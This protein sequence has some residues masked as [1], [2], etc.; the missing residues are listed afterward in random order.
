MVFNKAILSILTIRRKNKSFSNRWIANRTNWNKSKF[1]QKISQ[2]NV[3]Y[4]DTIILIKRKIL[5]TF[6]VMSHTKLKF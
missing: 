3:H 1:I 2:I 6:T 5:R 4:T